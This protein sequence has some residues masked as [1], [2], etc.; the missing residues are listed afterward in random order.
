MCE[1]EE[2]LFTCQHS[3]VRKK[4]YCHFARNDPNHQC[5]GVKVLKKTWLQG[6][7]CDDCITAMIFAQQGLTPTQNNPQ[8][9]RS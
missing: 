7:P 5:F 1:F 9:N 3:A 2:F 8:G 4:T 6:K